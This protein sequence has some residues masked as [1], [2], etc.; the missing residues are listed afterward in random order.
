[1]PS[2]ISPALHFMHCNQNHLGALGILV[3]LTQLHIICNCA[4][5]IKNNNILP[6]PPPPQL[7]LHN[8]LCCTAA[9]AS[10]ALT[11]LKNHNNLVPPPLQ[12]TL[13]TP[14]AAALYA[15]TQAKNHNNL[16]QTTPQLILHSPLCC[17]TAATSY[18]PTQTITHNN[19]ALPLP[20]PNP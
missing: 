15:S 1:M 5:A 17:S 16:V 6:E 11:Q 14:F 12:S 2:A 7:I 8:T 3:P 9:D 20:P 10:Y 19:H 13:Q 4:S 18:T